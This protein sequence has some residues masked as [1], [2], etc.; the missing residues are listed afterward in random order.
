MMFKNQDQM[1]S[2]VEEKEKQI[3]K[4]IDRRAE[5]EG[6]V[7]NKELSEYKYL[8]ISIF[9]ADVAHDSV[10]TMEEKKFLTPQKIDKYLETKFKDHMDSAWKE[11]FKK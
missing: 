1:F 3:L 7:D 5:R 9:D 8:M 6:V 10:L 2:Y 4:E 11:M